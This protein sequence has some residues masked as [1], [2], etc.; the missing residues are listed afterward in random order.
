MRRFTV[1]GRNTPF[2]CA[3]CGQLVQPLRQGGLRNHCPACLHSLHLDINPGDRASDCGGL[4]EPVG[5]SH[6]GSKGWMIIS[7]CRKCGE[8]KRNR[9]ALDDPE[10]P[11]DYDLIVELSSRPMPAGL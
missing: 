2:V 11:D 4:L 9:A 10:Q 8:V 6:S 5:V 7:R 3:N 1:Q